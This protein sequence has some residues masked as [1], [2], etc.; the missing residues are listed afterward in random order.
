MKRLVSLFVIAAFTMPIISSCGEKVEPVE[1]GKD[2]DVVVSTITIV[3]EIE[4]IETKVYGDNDLVNKKIQPKWEVGDVVLGYKGNTFATVAEFTVASVGADGKAQFTVNK[5]TSGIANGETYTMFYAPEGVYDNNTGTFSVNWA[6]QDGTIGSQGGDGG[7][8]RTKA[9]MVAAPA[10][11]TDDKL[12]LTFS[13]KMDVY[14]ITGALDSNGSPLGAMPLTVTASDGV[15]YAG[16]L[17]ADGFTSKEKGPVT[18]QYDG[19]DAYFMLPK[20]SVV[21]TFKF[22]NGN[23]WWTSTTQTEKT[24]NGGTFTGKQLKDDPLEPL[25]GIFSVSDTKRV[26]FAEGNLEYQASTDKWKFADEQWIA[27]GKGAGNETPAADRATQSEWIDLFGYGCT[28]NFYPGETHNTNKTYIEYQP[29]TTFVYPGTDGKDKTYYIYDNLSVINKTDWGY[30]VSDDLYSWFTLNEEEWKYFIDRST[31]MTTNKPQ[32]DYAYVVVNGV[33]GDMFFP[34]GWTTENWPSGVP[35][36]TTYNDCG[37]NGSITYADYTI[38][39]FKQIE[40]VAGVV[41]FPATTGHRIGE[42]VKMTYD[43][44]GNNMTIGIYWSTTRDASEAP[45]TF[46]S[47]DSRYNSRKPTG[48]AAQ[49]MVAKVHQ[50][51]YMHPWH[52]MAVRLVT[53]YT[54]PKGSII[55]DAENEDDDIFINNQ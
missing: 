43:G 9:Y 5:P 3:G 24:Y 17:G 51:A 12:V 7:I 20:A 23:S 34:D 10:T 4:Q 40:A 28:G 13:N 35:E 37:K 41:F 25:K 30:N 19:N 50:N 45:Y 14:R 53:E 11:V 52:G 46:G 29:W 36:P 49:T 33:K 42:T 55:N 39:Q 8:M 18:V 16:V 1:N 27:F 26:Q 22:G 32:W 44:G 54:G 47:G 21:R 15:T 6:N 48:G 2:P 38:E 31:K